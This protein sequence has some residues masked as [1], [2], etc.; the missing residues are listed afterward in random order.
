MCQGTQW[1]S[2][3]RHCATSQKVAGSIPDGVTGIFHWQNTSGRTMTLEVDSASNRN[4][5][6]KYFLGVKAVAIY[7]W[8]PYHFYVLTVFKSVSLNLLGLS[9]PVQAGNVI[10]LKWKIAILNLWPLGHVLF[11]PDL[12]CWAAAC[13]VCFMTVCSTVGHLFCY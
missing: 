3:L 12:I 6:Q 11:H 10:A 5:Y 8:E 13:T 9:E 7:S 1:H 2:W 4:E